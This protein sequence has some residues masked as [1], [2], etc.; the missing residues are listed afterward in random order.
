MSLSYNKKQLPLSSPN[1]VGRSNRGQDMTVAAV[2]NLPSS[3][4]AGLWVAALLLT[5]AGR[6]L[7]GGQ[8]FSFP[9]V[10]GSYQCE[11]KCMLLAKPAILISLWGFCLPVTNTLKITVYESPFAQLISGFSASIVVNRE[12]KVPKLHWNHRWCLWKVVW[13]CTFWR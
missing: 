12:N 11:G 7:W 13:P 2:C 9:T 4:S 10:S 6:D 3:D 5:S 1:H 8:C